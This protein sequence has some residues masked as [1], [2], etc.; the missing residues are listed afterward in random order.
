M[1]DRDGY[2]AGVPCWV[3]TTQPDPD[4]AAEFYGALFGWETEDTMPEDAPGKYFMARIRGRDAAAVSCA[5]GAR[6]RS[7]RCGTRTSRSTARMTTAEKVKAAGGSVVGS[8]STSSTPAAWPS[9]ADPQG[10]SVLLWQPNQHLGSRVVNEHGT[11][12][13]NDLHTDRHRGREG[14]LRRGVRL[15]H[16]STWAAASCT[17]T[18]PAYGDLLEERNP[19]RASA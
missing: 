11:V 4:A 9:F 5:D 12:N 6:T 16:C 7:P 3:D 18:L 14:V 15:G 19:G 1:P 2:I 13:F 17:W 8:R 10:A